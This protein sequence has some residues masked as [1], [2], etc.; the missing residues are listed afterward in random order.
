MSYCSLHGATGG[1]AS[2]RMELMLLLQELQQ[3]KT[4]QQLLSPLPFPT[5][6]PLL[7]ASVASSKT[8]VADPIRYLQSLSH[9]MLQTVSKMLIMYMKFIR[10]LLN[11]SWWKDHNL[12][13][14]RVSC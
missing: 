13:L 8:V 11:F 7:A 2:V 3:E 10:N 5:S 9:D 1:L 14:V 4:N 12:T 6:L